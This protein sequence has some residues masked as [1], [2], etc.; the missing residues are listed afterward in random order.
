MTS[1]IISGTPTKHATDAPAVRWLLRPL[2]ASLVVA[3]AARIA[4]ALPFTPVPFTLQPLAV[5]AVGLALSPW[6][7]ALALSFYLLEGASGVPVFSPT[8]PG[9]LAQ[10][11]G[12][13]GGFLLSYPLVAFVCSGITR[14]MLGTAPRFTAALLGCFA[15]TVL[16]FAAGSAWLAIEAHLNAR[17]V[18]FSAVL[19]FVPGEIVK[20]FAAAGT[21]RAIG[22][23]ISKMRSL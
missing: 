19:P 8:G 14:R 15:A 21:F 3:V 1:Q 12:F 5:L 18:L 10:L 13:T 9:G 6:E 2:C 16:L 20:I 4:F 17:Q 7:A 23:S 22:P 11:F